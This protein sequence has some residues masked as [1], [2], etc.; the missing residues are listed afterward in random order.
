MAS[1]SEDGFR[2]E[3]SAK[4]KELQEKKAKAIAFMGCK[5]YTIDRYIT[6]YYN[7]R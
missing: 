1:T 4:M 3:K 6:E 2:R 5:D 7:L